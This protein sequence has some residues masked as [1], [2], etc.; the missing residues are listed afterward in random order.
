VTCPTD[1]IA[2]LA[3]RSSTSEHVRR[4]IAGFSLL[5][6]MVAVAILAISLS[7][8]Y[9]SQIGAIKIAQRARMIHR[10]TLLARCKMG[11]IEEKV[12]K[13]GLPAVLAE[14]TDA[15]CVD[16]E[17]EGFRCEW[18]VRRVVLPTM[19]GNPGDP[20]AP[21]DDSAQ[22]STPTPGSAEAPGPNSPALPNLGA[23]GAGLDLS[24]IPKDPKDM[25][26]SNL[27]ALAPGG[28]PQDMIAQLALQFGFPV[29][30]PV[31]EE[32]TRRAQIIVKWREGTKEHRF[33]VDQFL[34]SQ[35]PM[36]GLDPTL[37]GQLTGATGQGTTAPGTTTPGTTTPGTTTPG[38]S[39]LNPSLSGIPG[40]Q[41]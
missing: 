35:M 10:A 17:I 36:P 12:A 33:S 6:V 23:G 14:G 38:A 18:K 28:S 1:I 15:C 31:L 40:L 26:A 27:M 16:G 41:Q 22:A 29:L 11:E 19:S 8:I 32:Q 24:K 4:R 20:N 34:V 3:V 25:S 30:K 2:P 37:Q 21:D 9:S 5:E 39:T 13:E 7:A